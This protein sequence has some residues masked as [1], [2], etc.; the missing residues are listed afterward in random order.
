MLIEKL[1][2]CNVVIVRYVART[3]TSNPRILISSPKPGKLV[4]IV[5][6][7]KYEAIVMLQAGHPMSIAEIIPPAPPAVVTLFGVMVRKYLI[8]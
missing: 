6:N 8:L 7:H 2:I 4:I 3:S 5:L 1:Q